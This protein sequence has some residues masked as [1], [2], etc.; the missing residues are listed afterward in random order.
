MNHLT[1]LVNRWFRNGGDAVFHGH[2]RTVYVSTSGKTLIHGRT[3][4]QMNDPRL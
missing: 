3:L 2:H 4:C 1:R